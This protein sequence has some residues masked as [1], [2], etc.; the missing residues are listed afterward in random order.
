MSEAKKIN[1]GTVTSLSDTDLVLASDS[2][3]T[4][5]PISVANL[6]KLFRESLQIGGRNLVK[7]SAL[8]LT[9][10][11]SSAKRQLSVCLADFPAGTPV[12]LSFDYEYQGVTLGESPRFGI[13]TNIKDM[14]T[15]TSYAEC[16]HYPVSASGKGRAVRTIT[17][18]DGMDIRTTVLSCFIQRISGGTVRLSNVK[19]ERG[20]VATDWTP[21]PEDLGWGG[22]NARFTTT[23]D[24]T[25]DSVQKGGHRERSNTLLGRAEIG[26]DRYLVFGSLDAACRWLGQ[27]AEGRPQ[28]GLP[29][30]WAGPGLRPDDI[31]RGVEPLL[32]RAERPAG[33]CEHLGLRDLPRGERHIRRAAVCA[34][35]LHPEGGVHPEAHELGLRAVGHA[36]TGKLHNVAGRKGV[37][38][39]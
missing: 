28:E 4:L 19:V 31:L 23:Y 18:P 20:N 36:D 25:A 29:A 37:A 33:A 11:G 24:F 1:E 13:Q 27:V 39:V 16:L 2:S 9:T 35:V 7:D 6:Q 8:D 10:V 21:A 15:Y 26:T 5:R 34:H 22:V 17:L 30:P 32:R 14:G 3:G 12:T 38:Y